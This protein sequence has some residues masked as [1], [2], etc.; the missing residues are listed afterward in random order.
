[1]WA[2]RAQP[3]GGAEAEDGVR[4]REPVEH[5]IAARDADL[6]GGGSARRETA[7]LALAEA[8]VEGQEERIV[9]VPPAGAQLRR[10]A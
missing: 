9:L 2:R 7:R 3:R 10:L 1:M 8:L 5:P 4:L 6:D